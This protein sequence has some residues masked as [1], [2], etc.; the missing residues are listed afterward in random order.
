MP[1]RWFDHFTDRSAAGQPPTPAAARREI[2]RFLRR[3]ATL[4]AAL[5]SLTLAGGGAIAAFEGTSLWRGINWAVDIVATTGSMGEPRTI[6]G[7]LTKVVLIT[8]G[9]GT[10][11]YLLVT[12]VELFVAG[13]MSGLLEVWRMERQIER[14]RDHYLICGF[15]RV[16]Q[17]VARDMMEAG[18][19][20]VVID[21][22][23]EQHETMEEMGVLYLHGPAADDALL[24]EAGIKS[25]RA[26]IACVDS[27]AENIFVTLSARELNPDVEIVAR[28]SQES[29]ERKLLRAGAN[30]VISPYKASGRAMATI[31][32]SA[33]PQVSR[34]PTGQS[35][36]NQELRV[37]DAARRGG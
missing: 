20:F 21:D 26:V 3:L 10:L 9:L 33:R 17:Q 2:A 30:D 35:T 32:L 11:F 31:A 16:G 8:L 36:P 27:D 29:S 22:N 24:L 23:V 28:A 1:S 15:G 5:S 12:I 25:A 6:G 37:P 7:E 18:V 13:H 34:G 4:I 19:D 14:L